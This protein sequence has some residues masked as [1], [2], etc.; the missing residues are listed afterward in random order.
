MDRFQSLKTWKVWCVT[1]VVTCLG[2]V[3][4]GD[5]NVSPQAY[6]V[7]TSILAAPN[8][9]EVIIDVPSAF[10]WSRYQQGKLGEFTYTIYPDG[11]AKV[12]SGTDRL[13]EEA[14]IECVAALMCSVEMADSTN[15]TVPVERGLRPALPDA[16]DERSA[17]TYVAQWILMG[18]APEIVAVPPEAAPEQPENEPL[19]TGISNGDGNIV[20]PAIEP[21]IELTQASNNTVDNT[22]DPDAV[23]E[24]EGNS[25]SLDGTLNDAPQ[26][27]VK[28]V[29]VAQSDEGDDRP[30]EIECDE[31]DPFFPELC[32]GPRP[33]RPEVSDPSTPPAVVPRREPTG[34][35]PQ[36]T[37]A[38]VEE[39]E[40][41]PASADEGWSLSDLNCSVTASASLAGL[42]GG[43]AKPRVSL[44]C[45]TRITDRLS[46]RGALIGYAIPS[47]Q[48]DF[49]PDFTYAFNYKVND[50]INL[51]YSNYS[52]SFSDS[53]GALAGLLDGNLRAS[54]K[55]P[56]IPLPNDR[57]LPCTASIGLPDVASSSLNLSCGYSIT[58]DLRVGGTAYLYLLGE[59]DEFS[60]DYSYTASYRI[61]DDWRLSYNNYSNNRF[62]W[63]RG[64]SPGPGLLG[65]SISL[66]HQIE[67]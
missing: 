5:A 40:A 55:L 52:A 34:A 44:G 24:D 46:F 31:V 43:N 11:S 14:R 13:I 16:F 1:T 58:P 3:L 45:G 39:P 18:T 19:E 38:I 37:A 35:M 6:F 36:S 17:A 56:D 65:G 26:E 41:A 48:E 51:S 21:P 47:H 60:P 2:T 12:M 59:Q 15:F 62:P 23:G 53:D 27:P 57:S 7:D 25:A 49:D 42:D 63:N 33:L 32:T 28:D 4:V 30:S 8:A 66:T 54:Y 64:A 20:Q 61:N 22:N 9:D 50:R 29:A 67:F 10:H